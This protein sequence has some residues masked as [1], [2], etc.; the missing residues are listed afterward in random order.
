MNEHLEL[1]SK[2][3]GLDSPYPLLAHLL[4]SATVA[5]VLYDHWL[6]AG[7]RELLER[8]IGPKARET[9]MYVVGSHDVGKASPLFQM[10]Y[11]RDDEHWRGIRQAIADSG[12]YAEIPTGSPLRDS[13]NIFARRHE[14]WSAYCIGDG[15]L[16]SNDEVREKWHALAALGHHGYFSL[17]EHN[18][19]FASK[20][21]VAERELTSSG[22]LKAQRDVLACVADACGLEVS[23]IPAEVSPTVTL[24][25]S[26]LTILADRIASGLPFV[27][28]GARILA[29]YPN[30][31]KNPAQWISQRHHEALVRVRDT[32][33]IYN[34]WPSA[35][36]AKQSILG[37]FGLRPIQKEALAVGGGVWSLMAQTGSGK[38]EAALL[39]HSTRN[40]R[41]IFLLP[42][43]ATSNAIMRRVQKA[44][45]GTANV[46][47]LAHGLASV[48][49]FYVN[50]V[51]VYSDDE[52]SDSRPDGLY[53]SSFVKNGAE[54]LLAPVCV[55]T[56]DQALLASLP[57]KW[58]HLRLLALAN[59]HIVIDEVHTLDQYQTK[60]LEG[61]MPWL[62]ATKTRVT[63]LTAT[64]PSWQ[65]KTLMKAYGA[66]ESQ[67]GEAHF[68]A[69]EVL[70][71]SRFSTSSL[72][73]QEKLIR[74][75]LHD[76][77]YESLV[78]SHLSW[79]RRT[80]Q[81]FPLARIGIICNTVARAQELGRKIGGAERS[82]VLHSRMTAEHR[83]RV[84]QALESALGPNGTGE[85]FSLVGTQAIE[86]SLD[87][88]L[89]LLRTEICPP[90]SV[91]QRAGRQWRR[92]DERRL[93]RLPGMD[94]QLLSVVAIAEGQPWQCLPYFSAELRRTWDWLARHREIEM[95]VDAQDFIETAT[96][97]FDD[98]IKEDDIE[99]LSVLAMRAREGVD[100]RA[101]IAEALVPDAFVDDFSQLTQDLDADERRT[102]LS[103]GGPTFRVILGGNPQHI[104]G[105][106]RGTREDLLRIKPS[107]QEAL[108]EVLRASIPLGEKQVNSLLRE[109]ISPL[110]SARSILRG[111]YFLP[112]ADAFYDARVGFIGGTP[113]EE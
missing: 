93:L 16:A 98:A 21:K 41:L 100:R 59:A 65:R 91:I 32:A 15:Y 101:R 88:D 94:L 47:A 86:A 40:E 35:K 26:G 79:Y 66:K 27:E 33:G 6:R 71:D 30:A 3:N 34:P 58:I 68:P 42:T 82:L 99:A 84:T 29:E 108:R 52:N 9:T 1:W 22:W 80:R 18:R 96:I 19:V 36:A 61:L 104:P 8:E 95:P 4:D 12:L 20:R 17:A 46:A 2:D 78:E 54:R 24:L 111:Y 38:T 44:Y 89:D 60:L 28:G 102:R 57:A 39:R 105:A 107:D 67:L 97:S 10:Q 90:A 72:S 31:L 7:L 73:S 85:G 13:E 70:D 69:S 76:E 81:R 25:L 50:P 64:M 103:E 63:F 11:R 45:E 74:V 51:S 43:Q 23:G 109:G 49:D 77:A 92:T 55:G 62:S 5:E 110:E 106:F 87:I 83:R 48:E 75:D 53:P 112:N 56:V 37:D 14:Q 113:E